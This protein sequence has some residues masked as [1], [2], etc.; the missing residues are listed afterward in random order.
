MPIITIGDYTIRVTK[1]NRNNCYVGEF[2]GTSKFPTIYGD[3]IKEI[4]ET[5]EEYIKDGESN[6]LCND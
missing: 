3:N 6:E 4:E 1:H 2:V 5:A